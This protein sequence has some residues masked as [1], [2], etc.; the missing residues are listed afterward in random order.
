MNYLTIMRERDDEFFG[1]LESF[2]S[3]PFGIISL[4]NIETG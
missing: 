2:P 4:C 3:I 1:R